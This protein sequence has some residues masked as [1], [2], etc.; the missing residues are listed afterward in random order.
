MTF[1]NNKF[2]ILT[3]WKHALFLRR[4]ETPD[5]K[6]LEYYLVELNRP[7]QPISM[8]KAWVGMVLLAED[9]WFYSSPTPS[10]APPGRTFGTST[11]AW[12]DRKGAVRDAEGY[13]MQPVNDAYQ[14]R[15]IDFR[16]CRFDLSSARRGANGCVV[17][18]RFLP[19]SVGARDLHVVCKVVDVLR[20]PDAANSLDGEARAYAALQDLQGEVIPTLY[21][22]YE[23]WGIL[24]LLALEPVGNAVSEDEQIDQ[25]LRTKMKAAL[26]H[27]H[28]AGF[29]HGDIARRNFCRTDSGDVFLVDLER[30]Q[31]SGNPSELGDEMDQVDGM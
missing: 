30:C 23:V 22:F 8:L 6:T 1:N 24:Q 21:G 9:D 10:S 2:G 27:I 16:L 15:A 29:I 18:A 28:N 12:K 14:C 7:G 3:N 11:A 5:R 17:T 31:L 4:A 26:Q 25:T 20:Y 13:H 19:S